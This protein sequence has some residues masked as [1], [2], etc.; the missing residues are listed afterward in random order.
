MAGR[1]SKRKADSKAE[2]GKPAAANGVVHSGNVR[3]LSK[4][5][6]PSLYMCR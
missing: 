2:V 3:N 4:C 1:P 5:I 6:N